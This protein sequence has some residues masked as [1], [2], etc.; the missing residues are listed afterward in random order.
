MHEGYLPRLPCF[1]LHFLHSSLSPDVALLLSLSSLGVHGSH[2][3]SRFDLFAGRFWFDC[4]LL[5]AMLT[6]CVG[7]VVLRFF[8]VPRDVVVII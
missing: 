8:C 5:S 1:L 2:I 7:A 6:F 4:C 3:S